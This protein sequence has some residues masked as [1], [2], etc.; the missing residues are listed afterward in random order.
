MTNTFSIGYGRPSRLTEMSVNL[1][2]LPSFIKCVG[3]EPGR[4]V[5]TSNT[6]LDTRKDASNRTWRY[7]YRDT[8][9]VVT[10]I[11]GNSEF[12]RVH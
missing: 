2:K 8:T 10:C 6:T 5:K 1:F 3:Y 7:D 4:W 9:I 11:R 12:Y